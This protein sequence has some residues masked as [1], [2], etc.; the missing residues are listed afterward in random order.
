MKKFAAIAVLLAIPCAASAQSVWMHNRSEMLIETYGSRLI[1]AYLTPREGLSAQP[2][3]Y[4]VH[5]SID[6]KSR[7]AGGVARVFS[8]KC[9]PAAYE[10]DGVLSSG[11]ITLTGNAPIRDANC[12][13]TN[14]RPDKLVFTF[15]RERGSIDPFFV[16]EWSANEKT[17]DENEAQEGPILTTVTSRGMG[18][19]EEYCVF[20]DIRGN[21]NLSTL[22]MTCS[23]MDTR[24]S[25]IRGLRRIASRIME[26]EAR[27]GPAAGAKQTLHKCPINLKD[28]TKDPSTPSNM[29]AAEEEYF[30]K[31]WDEANQLMKSTLSNWPKQSSGGRR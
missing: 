13:I 29:E 17:C 21:A 10:V 9:G 26:I 19:H 2:G 7:A 1:I 24:S 18:F 14:F 12:R 31:I 15:V 4:L 8:S 25:A 11:T 20:S 30:D 27:D 6:L 16:G 22:S 5:G 3:D 28:P 23:I